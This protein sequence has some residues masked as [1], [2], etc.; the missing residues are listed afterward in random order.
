MKFRLPHTV[1]CFFLL[2]ETFSSAGQIISGVVIDKQTSLPLPYASLGIR[3]KG[4]G[5]IAD[6]RGRFSLSISQASYRDSIIISNIGYEST[7][8]LVK[9]FTLNELNQIKLQPKVKE[10]EEV[11]VVAKQDMLV[12]GNSTY[13]SDF[14]GWGD[15]TSSRGRSKGLQIEP[16]E[17]P[18][19][20]IEFDVR[21]KDNDFDSVKLRL[22]I[23]TNNPNS[24][25]AKEVLP[26]NVLF[27]AVKNQHWVRVDLE[28]YNISMDKPL[29][30]SVEWVDS[31][32]SPKLGKGSYLLTISTG[33]KE[34]YSFYREAPEQPFTT[35]FYKTSPTMYFK[36]YKIKAN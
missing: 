18:T 8:I 29:W 3:D 2:F 33:K 34:G 25:S 26:E 22:H 16:K 9:N 20:I 7:T 32:T 6:K 14:T 4:I 17:F 11:I 35:L 1:I 28:K 36:G 23:Y 13:T 19:K 10:L 21:L 31:W 12:L 15:F 5:C 27:T 30:A 24:D